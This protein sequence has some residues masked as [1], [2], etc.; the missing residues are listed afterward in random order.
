MSLPENY[1]WMHFDQA[2]YGAP[3]RSTEF[4]ERRVGSPIA[5]FQPGSSSSVR[6]YFLQGQLLSESGARAMPNPYEFIGWTDVTRDLVTVGNPFYFTR[7]IPHRNPEYPSHFTDAVMNFRGSPSFPV[8]VTG[9]DG[10]TRGRGQGVESTPAFSQ[11]EAQVRYSQRPY[12]IF[13]DAEA[14]S[15]GAGGFVGGI[16]FVNEHTLIRFCETKLLPVNRWQTVP[17]LSGIKWVN[18]PSYGAKA[19]VTLKSGFL[20]PEGD[21]SVTWY[22]VPSQLINHKAIDRC[23]GS[24]NWDYFGSVMAHPIHTRFAPGTLLCMKPDIKYYQYPTAQLRTRFVIGGGA[25]GIPIDLNPIYADIQFRFRYMPNISK[26]PRVLS[27]TPPVRFPNPNLGIKLGVNSLFWWER[28]DYFH[29]STNGFALGIIA[30]NHEENTP[31]AINQDSDYEGPRTLDGVP[32]Y[33]GP[34]NAIY[35][36]ENFNAMLSPNPDYATLY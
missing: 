14:A 29:I 9:L 36:F 21:L 17:A 5:N 4:R 35:K 7:I 10:K 18:P 27:G 26:N 28:K 11:W 6:S 24:T 31:L 34:E 15:M 20:I 25:G 16:P 23:V 30:T 19:G 13:T 22:Q 12:Q 32:V 3:V 8:G 2:V 1:Q 33:G